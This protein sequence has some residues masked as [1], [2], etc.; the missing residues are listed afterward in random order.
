M[1]GR[2]V[3]PQVFLDNALLVAEIFLLGDLHCRNPGKALGIHIIANSRVGGNHGLIVRNR[4]IQHVEDVHGIFAK[5]IEREVE[6]ADS[7]KMKGKK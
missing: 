4:K 2:N 1:G 6:M 3:G 7:L 5:F